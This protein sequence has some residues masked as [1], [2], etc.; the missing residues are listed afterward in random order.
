VL[1]HCVHVDKTEIALMADTGTVVVHNPM[2]NLKLGSG[3]APVARMHDAG[4]RMTL[5]TDG[6]ISGNDLDMW[7]T[8]R[9]AAGLAKG[10]TMDP[11][12]LPA[13]EILH[14]A[15]L[16]GAEALGLGDRLGSLEAGKSADV[17]MLDTAVVHATPIF[18]PITHLVYSASKNDVG[19][20]FVEGRHLVKD[21]RLA[22]YDLKP[23]L[24]QTNALA[25]KIS[26]SLDAG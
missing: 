22:D 1:A 14:M 7:L 16:N 3:I 23:I 6:A 4:I 17:I 20:V 18:D 25:P 24:D 2:S 21:G 15:T 19:D 9:L 11:Q 8:M 13:A 5:G 26:A 10:G 12:V